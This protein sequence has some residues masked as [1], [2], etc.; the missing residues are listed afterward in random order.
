MR[1]E[2][3]GRLVEEE[4]LGA[5]EE[6]GGQGD[7]LPLTA[8]QP[9][10]RSVARTRSRSEPRDERRRRRRGR[11]V[12]ARRGGAAARSGRRGRAARRPGA[13]PRRGPGGRPARATGR[14]RGPEP[15][16]PSGRCS[17]SRHSIVVVLPAPLGPSTAVTAP[18]WADHEAPST[19]RT[20]AERSRRRLDAPRLQTRRD[21]LGWRPT[22]PKES[23]GH[24]RP[25]GRARPPPWQPSPPSWRPSPA[26]AA[27]PW[28]SGRFPPP[29]PLFFRDP[30]RTPD[31]DAA[32]R[33]R[34]GVPGRRQG[35]ARRSRPGR[36]RPRG[37]VA[38]G[39]HLPV[40]LR[41]PHQPRARTAVGSS[42]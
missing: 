10:D 1:V 5:A 33:R 16:P 23:H 13:S 12:Q 20:R 8:G 29:S 41:R 19:A 38:A 27:R 3:G 14:R 34:R 15:C 25:R 7:P 22:R 21:I 6:G 30:D 17:P 40:G 18:D 11:G 35:H 39:E 32:R 4:H 26:G 2:P 9:P 31:R 36:R 37:G 42:R 24:H 28:P